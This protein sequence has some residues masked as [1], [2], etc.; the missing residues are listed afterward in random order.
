MMN[1]NLEGLASLLKQYGNAKNNYL[2]A[3]IIEKYKQ[4]YSW[5]PV[6]IITK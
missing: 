1:D 2:K 4:K 5:D 3:K 6:D